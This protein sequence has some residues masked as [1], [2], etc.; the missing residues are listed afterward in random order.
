L[1]LPTSATLR[2]S[3]CSNTNRTPA[4]VTTGGVGPVAVA[5]DPLAHAAAISTIDNRRRIRAAD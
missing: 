3:S 1:K 4:G 2:A 5:H